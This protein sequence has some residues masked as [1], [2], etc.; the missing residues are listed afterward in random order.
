MEET[1]SGEYI[2]N[3]VAPWYELS[4]D[5][6]A[7]IIDQMKEQFDMVRRGCHEKGFDS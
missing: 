7:A 1:L 3:F 5:D 4:I 6:A 2:E